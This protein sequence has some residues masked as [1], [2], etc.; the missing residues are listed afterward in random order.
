MSFYLEQPIVVA[1]G[2]SAKIVIAHIPFTIKSI[3][4][5]V[6]KFGLMNGLLKVIQSDN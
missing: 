6:K 1:K 5:A 4:A 3:N 2:I